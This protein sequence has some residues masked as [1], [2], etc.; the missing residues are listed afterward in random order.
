MHFVCKN[1]ELADFTTVRESAG[2]FS[3]VTSSSEGVYCSNIWPF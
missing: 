2:D 1:I 3:T